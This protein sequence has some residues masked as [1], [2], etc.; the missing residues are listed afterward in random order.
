M[1]NSS[2]HITVREKPQGISTEV[3]RMLQEEHSPL[4]DGSHQTVVCMYTTDIITGCVNHGCFHAMQIGAVHTPLGSP[5]LGAAHETRASTPV[6]LDFIIP[7]D[8]F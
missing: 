8:L 4:V 5:N 2:T 6:F 7:F 1:S 3:T